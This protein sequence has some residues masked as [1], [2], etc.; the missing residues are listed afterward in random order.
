MRQLESQSMSSSEGP[1][2][3]PDSNSHV[4]TPIIGVAAIQSDAPTSEERTFAM[5]AEL[6]QLFSWIIGPIIIY[7]VK[8]DSRFVRFHALQAVLW[9]AFLVVFYIVFFVIVIAG[10]VATI[11]RNGGTPP[12]PSA[13]PF[14]ILLCLYGFMGL[15]WLTT[16]IVSI[17]FAVK[18]QNGDWASYPLIGRL[19]KKMAGI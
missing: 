1:S 6:L 3:P 8:R 9:Q 17:Y 15:T 2:P 10:F 14:V 5:L 4:P 18:A 7:F 12:N 11:P 13:F 16:M 19:A